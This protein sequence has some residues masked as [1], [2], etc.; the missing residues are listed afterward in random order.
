MG[1][2]HIVPVIILIDVFN[3]HDITKVVC[4]QFLSV[5]SSRAVIK[6]EWIPKTL[7]VFSDRRK[8]KNSTNFPWIQTIHVS[9]KTKQ[10][11]RIRITDEFKNIPKNPFV[12]RRSN[13]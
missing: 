6:I 9:T 8:Y 11:L 7:K 4:L 12:R 3:Y 5:N 13:F 10:W 1:E 2:D